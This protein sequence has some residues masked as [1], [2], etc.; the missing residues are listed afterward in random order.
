M[1]EKAKRLSAAYP[2][3]TRIKLLDLA[4]FE[5]GLPVGM[6]GTVVGCDDQPALL[7]RWDNG[8]TLSLLMEDRYRRLRPDEIAGERYGDLTAVCDKN[9]WIGNFSEYPSRDYPYT[10]EEIDDPATL[11]GR[12]EHGNWSLRTCFLCGGLAFVQQSNGGDEWLA[13]YQHKPGEWAPFDSISL[14]HILRGRG[15]D[16][17]EAYVNSLV[18]KYGQKPIA[19]NEIHTSPD[20]QCGATDGF[21]TVLC[22]DLADHQAWLEPSPALYDEDDP[23]CQ[24]CIEACRIWGLRPCESWEDYN[25]LLKSIGDEAYENAAVAIEDQGFG[26]MGGMA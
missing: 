6:R 23:L 22:Y 24:D 8:R 20:F 2:P 13:L 9:M 14:E 25:N 19:S 16:A 18:E 15:Q 11:M 1:N 21:P 5:D 10:F 4:N 3:G 12:M 17:F 7:M 26:G